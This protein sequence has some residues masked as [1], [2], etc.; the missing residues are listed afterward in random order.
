MLLLILQFLFLPCICQ[1]YTTLP[2]IDWEYDPEPNTFTFTP[3]RNTKIYLQSSAASV[4]DTDGLTLIPPSALEFAQTF[5]HDLESTFQKI[6]NVSIELIGE[7]PGLGIYLSL[8][9]D[10][11][12]YTYESGIKTSEGY[13]IEVTKDAIH[14][15]GA[16]ARGIWWGTRT[17]LQELVLARGSGSLE[18]KTGK[19][20]DSP[21]YPTRGFLLDAGRKWYSADVSLLLQNYGLY[22]VVVG[23]RYKY[24]RSGGFS[25]WPSFYSFVCKA[26]LYQDPNVISIPPKGNGCSGGSEETTTPQQILSHL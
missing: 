10:T 3:K 13:T 15:S 4:R 22:Q 25:S 17:L 6:K 26:C 12:Q 20:K 16:G 11:E 8:D 21:A 2:P 24:M 1:T 7:N 5:A 18:L 23:S 19:A 14:V 9:P